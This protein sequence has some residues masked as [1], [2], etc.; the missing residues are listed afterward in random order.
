MLAQQSITVED[1]GEFRVIATYLS[2]FDIVFIEEAAREPGME[3][4]EELS[5]YDLERE[6]V[7]AAHRLF[8]MNN[9]VK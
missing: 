8:Q 7:N 1:N 6:V 4:W 2:D 5:S 3:H 9:K